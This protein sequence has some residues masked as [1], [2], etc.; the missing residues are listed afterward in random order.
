MSKSPFE[1]WLST[2]EYKRSYLIFL[3][4]WLAIFGIAWLFWSVM[5]LFAPG[6]VA[7]GLAA[8]LVSVLYA[9]CLLYGRLLRVTGC[10][11]CANPMPFMRRE[12]GRRHMRDREDCVEMEYGREEWGRHYVRLDCKLVRTDVVTYRCRKCDQAWEEKIEL[13]GSGYKTVGRRDI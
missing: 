13:P 12:M 6:S 7:P 3:V 11:K 8:T 9:T 10:K 1:Q 4:E 2:Q 5:F